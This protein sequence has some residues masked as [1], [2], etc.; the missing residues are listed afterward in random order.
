MVPDTRAQADANSIYS[1]RPTLYSDLNTNE[2]EL[3]WLLTIQY[4]EDKRYWCKQIEGFTK[5]CVKIQEI[6]AINNH[7]YTREPTVYAV[8]VKLQNWFKLTNK[9]RESELTNT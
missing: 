9:A 1:H 6:V 7:V 2:Q 5:L 4:E 8:L 3:F